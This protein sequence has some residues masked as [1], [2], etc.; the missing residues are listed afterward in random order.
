MAFEVKP[1][2]LACTDKHEHIVK[3]IRLNGGLK[4]YPV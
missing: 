2:H 4:L 3:T 1:S